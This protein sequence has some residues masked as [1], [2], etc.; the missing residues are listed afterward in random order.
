MNECDILLI[1]TAC[2]FLASLI[3]KYLTKRN[4]G[5]LHKG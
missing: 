2:N 5:W 4:Q 1:T 3:T